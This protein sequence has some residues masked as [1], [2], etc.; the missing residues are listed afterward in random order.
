VAFKSW[1]SNLVPGDTNGVEDIFV[2][3]MTTGA[4]SRASTSAAGV[5]SD[6][7]SSGLSLGIDGSGNVLVAFLSTSGTLT[8]ASNGRK[9]AFVKNLTAG[10]I[11]CVS[12][13]ATGALASDNCRSVSLAAGG[14][15]HPL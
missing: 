8:G 11:T 1:A 2:K 12:T 10:A 5:Q 4:I 9:Q 3:N 7:T 13:S 15:N 6:A 14:S